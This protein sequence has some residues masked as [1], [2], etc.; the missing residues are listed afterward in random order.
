MGMDHIS[1][2]PE[3]G[4]VAM[5]IDLEIEGVADR[6]ITEMIRKTV[7]RLGRQVDRPGEW[8]VTIAP[9]EARGRWDLGIRAPTGWH[10]TS[11]SE[12]LAALPAVVERTLRE[13]LIAAT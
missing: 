1:A 2:F 5:H 4:G 6:A 8:R 7:R 10:L 3:R 9:S 11:F 12:S 13:Q